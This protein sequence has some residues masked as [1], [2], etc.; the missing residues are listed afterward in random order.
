MEIK[1]KYIFLIILILLVSSCTTD[2]IVDKKTNNTKEL[3][4]VIIGNI[5]W[6]KDNINFTINP[7]LWEE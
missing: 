4:N 5:D 2:R 1:I 7:E 3:E 6:P